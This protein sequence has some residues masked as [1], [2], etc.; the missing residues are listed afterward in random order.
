MTKLKIQWQQFNTWYYQ[1]T[2]KK[3]NNLFYMAV[4]IAILVVLAVNYAVTLNSL[5]A[6]RGMLLLL[7]LVVFAVT[8][9][10]AYKRDNAA[11]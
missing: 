4:I 3:Q 11:R 2:G 1:L 8:F 9:I 6:Q 10:S 7:A 5:I